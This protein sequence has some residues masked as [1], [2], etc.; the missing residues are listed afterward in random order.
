M[1]VESI[2]SRM[3]FKFCGP[4]T[5]EV[6]E[7]IKLLA[8]VVLTW[9]APSL[10]YCSVIGQVFPFYLTACTQAVGVLL[11]L[12]MYK[13]QSERNLSCVPR[14]RIPNIPSGPHIRVMDKAA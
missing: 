2:D 12:W 13:R 3:P 14:R 1:K 7:G 11:G 10:L 4:R 9:W 5:S 6:S 8:G